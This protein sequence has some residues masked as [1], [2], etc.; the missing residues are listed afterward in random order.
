MNTHQDYF[1]YLFKETCTVS[2]LVFTEGMNFDNGGWFADGSISVQA[3]INGT[4]TAVDAKID[5]KYPVGN[6]Q[7]DFGNSFETYTFTFKETECDG[8]RVIGTAGGSAGFASC[9]EL[10]VWACE[11]AAVSD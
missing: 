4:W 2:S 1:G 8:I 10:E 5:A 3:L 6:L 9:A 11:T 7:S